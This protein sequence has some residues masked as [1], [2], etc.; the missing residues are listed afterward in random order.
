MVCYIVTNSSTEVPSICFSQKF[1]SMAKRKDTKNTK[2]L[3]LPTYIHIIFKQYNNTMLIR[4]CKGRGE[5]ERERERGGGGGAVP[6]PSGNEFSSQRAPTDVLLKRRDQCR[7]M[8]CLTGFALH[9][10]S[11][12]D[13]YVCNVQPLSRLLC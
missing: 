13:I 8:H 12:I 11:V 10:Q 2:W 3:P 6:K 9:F 5:R 7:R 1:R 4:I